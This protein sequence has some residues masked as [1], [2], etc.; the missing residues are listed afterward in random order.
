MNSFGAWL[1]RFFADPKNVIETL[2]IA[3]TLAGEII[4]ATKGTETKPARKL[5]V[6]AEQS[7]EL[8]ALRAER[9]AMAKA[10]LATTPD[11]LD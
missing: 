2:K 7:A 1:K 3:S 6:I 4:D 5:E 8:Q 11:P 10:K 9:E